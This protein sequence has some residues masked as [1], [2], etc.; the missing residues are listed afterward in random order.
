MMLEFFKKSQIYFL[1][2]V[3]LFVSFAVVAATC[4]ECSRFHSGIQ[5]EQQLRESYAQLKVKNE[6]YL[7]KPDVAPGAAIKVRSN[8]MLLGIKIETQ[9]N[10]IEALKI[11]MKKGGNC[12]QCPLVEKAKS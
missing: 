5:K 2:S 3:L 11:E 7:K 1:F 10:K 12:D 4:D 6:D 8:I 9:D